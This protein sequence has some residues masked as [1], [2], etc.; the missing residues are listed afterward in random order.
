MLAAGPKTLE[1][2]GVTFTGIRALGEL[3]GLLGGRD[4]LELVDPSPGGAMSMLTEVRKICWLAEGGDL[5]EVEGRGWTARS[6]C[7]W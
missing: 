7:R 2:A 3:T 4:D 5:L 6:D 1:C